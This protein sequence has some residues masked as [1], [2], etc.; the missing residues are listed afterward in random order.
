[1]VPAPPT[2]SP[3]DERRWH[4]ERERRQQNQL[5]AHSAG[6]ACKHLEPEDSAP[7]LNVNWVQIQNTDGSWTWVKP[8]VPA[9]EGAQAGPDSKLSKLS[10]KSSSSDEFNDTWG[11]QQAGQ[12]DAGGA[13]TDGGDRSRGRW[14]DQD[15]DQANEDRDEWVC[16]REYGNEEG[17]QACSA[18]QQGE[19]DAPES[20]GRGDDKS[21]GDGDGNGD[22]DEDEHHKLS[23]GQRARRMGDLGPGEPV[24]CRSSYVEEP[25]GFKIKVGDLE[26]HWTVQQARDDGSVGSDIPKGWGRAG[27]EQRKSRGR[28]PPLQCTRIGARTHT[29]TN[30]STTV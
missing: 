23:A 4:R 22:D 20:D 11:S 10:K 14:G 18:D 19:H 24:W 17:P 3:E 15:S 29:K 6:L 26:P 2:H 8:S 27:V 7:E 9:D 28:A 1:M 5:S 16:Q 30:K 21:A 25:S 12:Q 13:C